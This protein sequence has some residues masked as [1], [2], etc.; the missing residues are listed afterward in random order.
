MPEKFNRWMYIRDTMGAN[1]KRPATASSVLRRPT[2]FATYKQ[3]QDPH[4]QTLREAV[5]AFGPGPG[6][7]KRPL[8]LP[9]GQS[10]PAPFIGSDAKAGSLRQCSQR[11]A[12]KDAVA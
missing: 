12:L 3:Q 7:R 10:S 4:A 1:A 2:K 5:S 8:R 9:E 6:R 11:L